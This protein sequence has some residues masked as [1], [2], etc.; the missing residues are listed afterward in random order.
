M[1]AVVKVKGPAV[2]QCLQSTAP[3]TSGNCHSEYNYSACIFHPSSVD[4]GNSVEDCS[5]QSTSKVDM[6]IE[7]TVEGAIL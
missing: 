4:C 5:F 2:M 1:F 7:C 3:M 6:I